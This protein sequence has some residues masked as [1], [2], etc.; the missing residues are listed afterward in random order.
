[1]SHWILDWITHGPDMPLYPGGPRFGLGLWNSVAGTMSV[2]IA[3]FATGVWLYVRATRARDPVG[4]YA[5]LAYVVLLLV[6]ML[7]TASAARIDNA[8]SLP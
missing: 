1:M 6:P 8:G 5:F 4:Q 7:S 3:M 2:E